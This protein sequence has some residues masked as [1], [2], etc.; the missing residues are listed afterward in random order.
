MKMEIQ[1][2][3]TYNN[4]LT[5]E[6]ALKQSKEKNLRIL[7]NLELDSLLK[8]D[9]WKNY[10]DAL[11]WAWSGTHISYDAG[12]T[13]ALVWNEGETKKTKIPLP[14]ND[15]WYKIKNKYGIPNGEKSNSSDSDARYLIRRQSDSFNGLVSRNYDFWVGDGRRGV[16]CGS[17]PSHRCGVLTAER[18]KRATNK[19]DAALLWLTKMSKKN[20]NAKEILKRLSIV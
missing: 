17:G 12:A 10:K 8:E 15:G 11:W 5:V 2:L 14:L 7:T 20:K 1:T 9:E 18:A 4:G 6:E 19:K 3:A 13:T 16:D